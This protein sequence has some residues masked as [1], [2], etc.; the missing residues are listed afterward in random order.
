MKGYS[1]E[2]HPE[3][4]E[5]PIIDCPRIARMLDLFPGPRALAKKC[6]K[7]CLDIVLNSISHYGKPPK[8]QVKLILTPLPK[9]PQTGASTNSKHN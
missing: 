4:L 9:G 6:L 8:V 1:G 3:V 2:K 7:D 5:V